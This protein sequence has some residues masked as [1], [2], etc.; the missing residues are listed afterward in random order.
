MRIARSDGARRNGGDRRRSLF[1]QWSEY[2]PI[3]HGGSECGGH[4]GRQRCAERGAVGRGQPADRAREHP[5]PA[6]NVLA[7]PGYVENGSTDPAVDWVTPFETETGCTVNAQIF[8]TSDEAFTPVLDEPRAV[9]RHLGV[10]RR[11]P[12]AR[13]RR[14]RPAG[15]RRPVQEL[16]RTSSRRSRT[17]PTTPS[18]ASHYGVPHGRGSNLLM[19]RT[20]EVT[21]A[22]TSWAQM[23]DPASAAGKVT[24]YDAPIYIADAA[25]VLMKTKPELNIKNPYA[26]DD[27]Q[28]AAAVDLL[29]QQ[30]PAITQYWVDYPSRW[31]RSGPATPTSARPGRSSPTC[32]RAR[33]RPSRSTSSSPTKGATGW[34]DT[35]MINSKTQ[36]PELRV[37]LHRPHHLARDQH[38]D[39]RMV[40]RGAGQLEVVRADRRPRTTAT[41]FHADDDAF[42][43]DVWYWQTPTAECLDG[44]TDVTCK[45]FDD[46]VKAWTEIKG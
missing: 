7:W 27:T 32:S 19:W 40:R 29:K 21:P 10:G 42:W 18:M 4:C 38:P 30:K 23:F 39:R 5:G 20:D 44:R 43:K 36:E 17:S 9:R 2:G 41:I 34:S 1:E 8:G 25:V 31:T 3:E 13:P 26:L 22:P 45:D 35:W 15:Q 33:R 11:Q 24:V 12:A 16:R 28:F 46:W 14:L 6:I 37:Q